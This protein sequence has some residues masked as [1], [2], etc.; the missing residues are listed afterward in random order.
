MALVAM[1]KDAASHLSARL[2]FRQSA[3]KSFIVIITVFLGSL[4][5][6]PSDT[7]QVIQLSPAKP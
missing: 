5:E 2:H 3:F 1:A 7:G 6:R 4:R